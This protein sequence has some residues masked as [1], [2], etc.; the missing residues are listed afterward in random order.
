M[1]IGLDHFAK[2]DDELARAMASRTLHRN[3]QGYTTHAECDMLAIGVS[4]ISKIGASYS[5]SLRTLDEYY[6]KLDAGQLPL[7]KG[8]SLSPDD[9]LRRDVM[10]TRNV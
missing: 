9:I 10:M 2:P 5:Q 7:E 8:F 6:A 1:Y 4:S 3:F